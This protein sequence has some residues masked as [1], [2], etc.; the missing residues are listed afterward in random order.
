MNHKGHE[1]EESDRQSKKLLIVKQILLVPTLENVQTM[2][3]KISIQM[4][5]FK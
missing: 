5:R 2:S 3:R 1:N 4:S